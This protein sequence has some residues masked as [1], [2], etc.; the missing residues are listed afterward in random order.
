[1]TGCT[2]IMVVSLKALTAVRLEPCPRPVGD[3][4]ILPGRLYQEVKAGVAKPVNSL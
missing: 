4:R 3:D 1:M 2:P